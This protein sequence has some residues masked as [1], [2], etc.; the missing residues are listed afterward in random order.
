MTDELAKLDATATAELIRSRELSAL[1]VVDAAIGRIEKLE[2][3]K[4]VV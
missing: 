4:S 1:E 2:D 3:R